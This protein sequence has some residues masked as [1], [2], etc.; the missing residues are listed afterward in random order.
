MICPAVRAVKQSIGF[1]GTDIIAVSPTA[2]YILISESPIL[3]SDGRPRHGKNRGNKH[4]T[5]HGNY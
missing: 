3:C 2:P 4:Q 5:G 1:K